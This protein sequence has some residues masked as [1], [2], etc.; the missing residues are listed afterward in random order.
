MWKKILISKK[1]MASF[2]YGI[3]CLAKYHGPNRKQ[4]KISQTPNWIIY[5]VVLM[6]FMIKLMIFKYFF[7]FCAY[8]PTLILNLATRETTNQFGMALVMMDY[9]KNIA[10]TDK[11]SS[12][13]AI[14]F[15]SFWLALSF[16]PAR[17]S[18]QGDVIRLVRIYIYIIET[19]F[20]SKWKKE[21]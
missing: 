4:S 2:Q 19:P 14:I 7:P 1:H 18:E 3:F 5:F 16:L 21:M 11:N 13:S 8:I 17:A 20:T 15:C 9:I 12:D 6:I 10:C